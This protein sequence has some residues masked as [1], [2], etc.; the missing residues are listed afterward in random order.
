MTEYTESQKA[1]LKASFELG[2]AQRDLEEAETRWK[3]SL[4]KVSALEQLTLPKASDV[5]GI[6]K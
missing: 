5:R 3:A 4:D 1:L 2:L 6:L